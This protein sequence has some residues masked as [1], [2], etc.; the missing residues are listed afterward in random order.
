[1]RVRARG[2]APLRPRH[3]HSRVTR[4]DPTSAPATAAALHP[5]PSTLA[6][7]AALLLVFG[8]ML[9]ARRS[10]ALQRLLAAGGNVNVVLV[11]RFMAI[12]TFAGGAI[13]L[14][15][16]AT[17][18]RAGRI[19]WINDVL[20]L[21]IVELSAYGASIAGAALIVL[22]RGLQ[23]RLDAAYHLT[24][25]VLGAG[26]L[27]ALA[28]ALDIEQA[29]FLAV[30]LVMFLPSRRFFYRR[31]SLFEERF[32]RG[33]LAA[34]GGV[35]A[36]AAV[37]AY[38]AYGGA[39]LSGEVFWRFADDAP[40]PRA[41]RALALALVALLLFSLA[42]LLRAARPPA[43]P[44]S[45]EDLASAERIVA[46]ACVANAHLAFLG[47]K[48]FVFDDS[49]R[50]FIMF[51]AAGQSWVALGDPVGPPE[52]APA[53]VDRFIHECDRHDVWPVFY[54][55]GPQL[56]YLYLDYGLAV[57]KLGEVARVSLRTFSLD[58]PTRRNLRRVWRKLA[59]AGCTFEVVAAGEAGPL[60]P[61]LRAISDE[62][63]AGKRT[64]EKAFS[65]GRF[66]ESF[67]AR[68]PVGLVRREGRIVAFATGWAAASGAELEVD[69]MRYGAA[70][71]P[72][73][74]R[75][76]LVEFMLWAKQH[77][78]G[79][80]NL[81]MVPL[82]GVKT[83]AVTP[84]WN[85]LAAMVRARGER[86]YNFQ[87]LREFKAWFYPEWEPSYLISPGGTKRPLVLAHIASLIS[88]GVSG[89]IQK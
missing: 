57:V 41:A 78:Y 18:P 32:T 50:A 80:F 29:S 20:P 51:G 49:R 43:R 47:D 83:S 39:A 12:A 4:L 22:A 61:T 67:I 38:L 34:I 40:A 71:P 1:M 23:R 14:I 36:T 11:P 70:A 72:G 65:L 13:L 88:G 76:L 79:H 75:Y 55:V 87:G 66:D 42:R 46:T 28:S 45:A 10:A 5:G 59:D 53:V 74:M 63:I 44:A 56:L 68:S 27:V 25:W 19:G 33:W 31:A 54:R 84:M 86:Y 69:L 64:R 3:H 16:G 15:S 30:M 48:Q 17:P 6:L 24:L 21:P 73:V 26:I 9:A 77:G 37:L 62:W 85:Q 2:L 8:A 58:G 89:A 60:L 81:G 7:L 52:L 35:V 82:S